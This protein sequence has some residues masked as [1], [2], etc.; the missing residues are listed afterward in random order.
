MDASYLAPYTVDKNHK[1]NRYRKGYRDLAK[2][3]KTGYKFN[4]YKIKTSTQV[5][6]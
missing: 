3:E 4:K 1:I 2:I 6:L 5:Y